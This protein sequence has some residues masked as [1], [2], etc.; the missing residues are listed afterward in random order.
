MA[1]RAEGYCWVME[2]LGEKQDFEAELSR[3]GYEHDN[4]A[5][6]VRRARADGIGSEWTANYF[7]CVTE[8]HTSRSNVYLGGPRGDWVKQFSA[9]LAT[10]FFGAPQIVRKAT[11]A[12]RSCLGM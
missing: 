11:R 6:S 2:Q 3:F 5:L 4:F 8:L 9:D 1:V 12:T 10:G 7:V